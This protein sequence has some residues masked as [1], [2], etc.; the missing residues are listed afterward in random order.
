MRASLQVAGV[1]FALAVTSFTP[2]ASAEPKDEVAAATAAWAQVL[3]ENDPKKV[4][5]TMR[6][7]G[8]HIPETPVR[9]GGR[10]QGS[11]RSK[12]NLR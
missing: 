4:L 8:D 9:P 2:T 5:P 11:S 1:G 10:L 12:S 7:F 6:F 3:G